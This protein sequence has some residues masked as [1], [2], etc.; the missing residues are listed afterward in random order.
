LYKRIVFRWL[1]IRRVHRCRFEL[2]YNNI[3]TKNY[4][5]CW[6]NSN[7]HGY[8]YSNNVTLKN[9]KSLAGMLKNPTTLR[10]STDRCRLSRRRAGVGAER[11][12]WYYYA[13]ETLSNVWVVALVR[14]YILWYT[15]LLFC[16]NRDKYSSSPDSGTILYFLYACMSLDRYPPRPGLITCLIRTMLQL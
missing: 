15:T 8:W 7:I 12:W 6:F 4:I 13:H 16:R 3:T 14:Y 9:S 2:I 1:T 5:R 10:R 11:Q